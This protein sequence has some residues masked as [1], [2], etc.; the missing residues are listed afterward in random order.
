MA[1]SEH[2]RSLDREALA[3]LA[4]KYVWW[5][6][7]ADAA[8]RRVI[9]QVMDI[10]DHDD[11]QALARQVGD[12]ALREVLAHAQA[13]WFRPR[14]WAYWHYRLGLAAVDQVPAAPVRHFD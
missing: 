5:S 12:D 13:G 1:A 10:G 8:P 6:D 14:S 7:P 11:V 3:R 9:A 4:A 2:P